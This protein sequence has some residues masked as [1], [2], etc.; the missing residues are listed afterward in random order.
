[1]KSVYVCKHKPITREE[2]EEWGKYWP[3]ILRESEYERNRNAGFSE[4]EEIEQEYALELLENLAREEEIK[5]INDR[6]V[7]LN[8]ENGKV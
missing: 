1:M 6:A 4:T 2:F 7:I 3:T 5:N 8:P